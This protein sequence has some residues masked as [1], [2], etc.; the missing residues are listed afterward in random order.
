MRALIFCIVIFLA[1]A[2]A[3]ART[4]ESGTQSENGAQSCIMEELV[5]Q[6]L[7]PTEEERKLLVQLRG[8]LTKIPPLS[9]KES[10]E[11]N[12]AALKALEKLPIVRPSKRSK[13][14]GTLSTK[15]IKKLSN[16]VL[17]NEQVKKTLCGPESGGYPTAQTGVCFAR[18][19]AVHFKA[20][21][22]GVSNGNI[23][24]IWVMGDLRTDG[25]NFWFHVA[26]TVR[27]DSGEWY[28]IDPDLKKEE[29]LPVD[30]WHDQMRRWNRSDG[31]MRIFVTPANIFLPNEL[32]K[33]SA[34]EFK[35]T[36]GFAL[37]FFEAFY[38]EVVGRPGPWTK[39]RTQ[40]ERERMMRKGMS[41]L[42]VT[43]R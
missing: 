3:S 26:T 10:R 23:K 43:D 4:I 30:K 18:A 32:K 8:D 2:F 38:K 42:G 29:L 31:K 34:V 5:A 37:D 20:L 6:V 27:T 36:T 28:V 9:V 22:S 40:R 24:K 11:Q 33:Y 35:K 25:K 16:K 1:P 19:M 7:G 14:K 39:L 21:Q 12:A 41:W 15:E 17:A 13:R